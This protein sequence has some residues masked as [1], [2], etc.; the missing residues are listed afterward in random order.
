MAW[1][2]FW[3]YSRAMSFC[4]TGM[5]PPNSERYSRYWRNLTALPEIGKAQMRSL[6]RGDMTSAI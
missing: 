4:L 6:T 2:V 5:W 1:G 3:W